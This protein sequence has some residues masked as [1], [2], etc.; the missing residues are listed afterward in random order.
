M[1]LMERGKSFNARRDMVSVIFLNIH[2][3]LLF[4]YVI[5]YYTVITGQHYKTVMFQYVSLSMNIF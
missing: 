3:L 4:V 1:P 5:L 2:L